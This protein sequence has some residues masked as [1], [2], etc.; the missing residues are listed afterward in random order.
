MTILGVSALYHDSAAAVVQDGKII[1]AAQ[2]ERFSRKKGDAA[3][4]VNAIKYCIESVNTKID[5]VVY[6]DNPFLTMDRWLTN[7][8][9]ISPDNDVIINKSFS[10]MMSNRLWIHEKLKKALGSYWPEG[11]ELY[12]CE[13]HIS[14]AASAFYP[15]PF[16][17]A[18]ILTIDGVGEWA[19]T[20]IGYGNGE[21]IDIIRQINY[22]DSLGLL[23]SAFTYFCGFKVNSGEYKLMG[24]APYGTPK[25]KKIILD[26]LI[27]ILDDGAFA[28]NQEYFTYMRDVKII[29][30]EFEKLFGIEKR[31]PESH[32]AKTYLD[33][34]ASIQAVIEEAILSL[35]KLAH[36]L[37]GSKNLV[38][39]GGT[40]LNCV[41]NGKIVSEEI[42]DN[43]WVQPAAGDAG[44]A[45]GCALYAT[46]SL[47][48][49]KRQ[50]EYM[51]SQKGSYLG[52]AFTNEEIGNFL[53][54]MKIVYHFYDNDELFTVIADYL[55][56]DKVIGL[57]QGRMEYGPRALG[58]RSIIANPMSELMQSKVNQKIKF[59]ESFR[60]FAP[61]VLAEDMSR[62][63][64]FKGTTSP[65]MLFTA[66][67]KEELCIKN[68][69][70]SSYQ[71]V[72]EMI[73]EKRSFIPAVT[74]IDFSSRIQTVHKETN[75]FFYNL[76]RA[77]RDK[78]G[79]GIVL[80][81]S[82]NVRGEPI[83]CTPNDAWKCFMHTDMDVLVIGN[84][85]ILK[86]EQVK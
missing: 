34:A 85:L 59:R 38:L 57:H 48:K 30:K 78:T 32:L 76:I 71:D 22:P 73:N 83:V 10:N 27:N 86:G 23:Y 66:Q 31:K 54:K 37:T 75:L 14:H 62:Y 82:F 44:G 46:Y 60:P 80:N 55:A 26:N 61:A 8:V 47:G 50:I 4:P 63:F 36:K 29:G 9:D 42:F 39:A 13:H 11:T 79:C 51:D 12:V 69:E 33:L 41:A 20:T 65:Y 2:E 19:T 81:T 6:Y 84:Y 64:D 7:I 1:A 24:L 3:I 52:P 72:Y 45:L 17:E 77:F 67:V 5:Q 25:Y 16:Q 40:A 49:N 53:D 28:L 15:S 35:A 70:K 56:E 18:A 21:E 74:H 68:R 58:N 43:V